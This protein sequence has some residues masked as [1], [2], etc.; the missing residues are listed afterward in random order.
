MKR[1]DLLK[2]AVATS[3]A[4]SLPL[5]AFSRP[6]PYIER[7]VPEVFAK[8]TSIV[9]IQ[10]P[11]IAGRR[12]NVWR[13]LYELQKEL[14]ATGKKEDP[15]F[16]VSFED[17]MGGSHIFSAW[18]QLG[19]GRGKERVY[20]SM[21]QDCQCCYVLPKPLAFDQIEYDDVYGNKCIVG[22]GYSK[23]V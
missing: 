15:Y 14:I 22:P 12:F 11:I 3:V 18:M 16:W 1:R 21:W 8:F 6:I 23:I 10:G 5:P 7:I 17:K 20:Y 4:A 2:G 13:E 19:T 9:H